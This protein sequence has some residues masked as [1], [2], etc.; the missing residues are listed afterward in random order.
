MF[1]MHE[2]VLVARSSFFRNAFKDSWVEGNEKVITLSD[3]DE[4]TFTLY[5]QIVYRG[6]VPCIGVRKS[7]AAKQKSD[8]DCTAPEECRHEYEALCILYAFVER[9]QDLDAKNSTSTAL[10]WKLNDEAAH[11]VYRKQR[12]KT[13]FPS[14]E[15]ISTMYNST[16]RGCPGQALMAHAYAFYGQASTVLPDPED[17]PLEFI[18]DVISALL[19]KNF[20]PIQ[21]RFL[22]PEDYQEDEGR[23]WEYNLQTNRSREWCTC[24]GCVSVRSSSMVSPT[25]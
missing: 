16:P 22:L 6:R 11:T 5:Q 24:H 25:P 10:I 2:K 13:C 3:V 18:W 19:S 1:V 21:H 9:I 7:H 14:A 17:V 4:Q 20:D 8:Q 12:G 15:A 23:R